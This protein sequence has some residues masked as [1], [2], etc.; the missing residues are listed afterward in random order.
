MKNFLPVKNSKKKTLE[1]KIA[2][3]KIEKSAREK[4]TLPV[5]IFEKCNF[6]QNFHGQMTKNQ[7]LVAKTENCSPVKYFRK[8]TVKFE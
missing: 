3:E 5:K 6:L 1:K 2:S 8:M 7:I 4:Q